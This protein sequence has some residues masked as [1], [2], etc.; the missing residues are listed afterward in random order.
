MPN[1]DLKRLIRAEM[2]RTG[3]PYA[4]ARS[5]LLA[6]WERGVEDGLP[7]GYLHRIRAAR[8]TKALSRA[9]V[10]TQLGINPLAVWL[11]ENGGSL[12]SG[13]SVDQIIELY[14]LEGSAAATLRRHAAT[15][16]RTGR[17]RRAVEGRFVGWGEERSLVL[18]YRCRHDQGTLLQAVL[19]FVAA[20]GDGIWVAEPD[21]DERWLADLGGTSSAAVA[22]VGRACEPVR[23]RRARPGEGVRGRSMVQPRYPAAPMNDAVIV[24]LSSR[25]YRRLGSAS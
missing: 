25:V 20:D 14:G 19:R 1:D 2:T 17:P 24:H 12:P 10:A 21:H 22:A 5:R 4:A 6:E 18:S 8:T 13:I 9:D 16:S 23:A 15:Q 11:L 3:E 7:A